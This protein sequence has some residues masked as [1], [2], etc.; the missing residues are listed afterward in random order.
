M[1]DKELLSDFV[2]TFNYYG[3]IISKVNKSKKRY[4]G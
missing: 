1:Y 2:L 4:F 3:D